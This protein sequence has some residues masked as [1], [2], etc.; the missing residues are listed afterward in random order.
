[1]ASHNKARVQPGLCLLSHV[2]LCG[3]WAMCCTDG[4]HSIWIQ[5]WVGATGAGTWG[6]AF[7]R[8]FREPGGT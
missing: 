2:A 8:G 6:H 1:M 5:L 7:Q 4:E 3:E